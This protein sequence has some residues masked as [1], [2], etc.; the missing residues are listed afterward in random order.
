MAQENNGALFLQIMTASEGRSSTP[1]RK[2]SLT[3]PGLAQ[4]G[5]FICGARHLAASMTA[6]GHRND[7]ERVNSRM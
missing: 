7:V 6:F 4:D 2:S 3:V 5:A 1:Q